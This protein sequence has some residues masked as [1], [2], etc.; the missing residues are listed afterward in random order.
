MKVHTFGQV[1][2]YNPDN[3]PEAGYAVGPGTERPIGF[4][5]LDLISR[6][7]WTARSFTVAISAVPLFDFTFEAFLLG[8]GSSGTI[9]GATAGLAAASL[10]APIPVF[11][12]G[13]TKI[14]HV[15]NKKVRRSRE[16]VYNNMTQEESF[17][18]ANEEEDSSSDS[19]SSSK[20]N[21]L[22]IDP[23]IKPNYLGTTINK[24]KEGVLVSPGGYHALISN[25][26]S[27]FINFS[28]VIYA[29]RQYWPKILVF[30]SNPA[31]GAG[32]RSAIAIRDPLFSAALATLPGRSAFTNIGGSFSVPTIGGFSFLGG[33]A[34]LFGQNSGNTYSVFGAINIGKRVCDRFYFDGKPDSEREGYNE[35]L[36]GDGDRGVYRKEIPNEVSKASES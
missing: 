28:D 19:S 31:G 10:T 3:L 12:S 14:V 27:V 18:K 13:N 5:S 35:S 16:G 8:G 30:M 25:A 20:V 36:C 22:D 23:D 2:P 9:V 1:I 17:L 34:P 6:V 26:G 24:P 21:Y 29:R 33:V 32:F 11:I 4:P 15:F 7:Y